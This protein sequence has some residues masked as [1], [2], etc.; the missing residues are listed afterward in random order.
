VL[1]LCA[2]TLLL[3]VGGS[4]ILP[5]LPSYLRSHGSTPGI[6]GIIMASYFAASV[7]TQYPAGKISDRFGRR[8]I[9]LGGLLLFAVGSVGFAFAAAAGYAVLFRSLQG[10]G[11]GAV[12]V[13][14]AA[15][16]ASVVAPGDRG[17]A[18]GAL[19]GSQMLALAIG[20][21][22]G[23]AIGTASMRV[24]FLAAAAS[25]LVALAP[26]SRIGRL[27]PAVENDGSDQPTDTRSQELE[28]L[29]GGSPAGGLS[30]RGGKRSFRFTAATNGVFVEFLATGLLIGVYEAC[31]TLLL[32]ARGASS[33]E[34]GLSWT[35]FALPFAVL[36]I[37]AGVLAEHFDR[38]LLAIG[39]LAASGLFC[40]LYPFLH[41]V[42]LLV[43]LGSIEAACSVI[44]APA[45]VLILT[46]A[47]PA[48]A[49]GEAQG[50]LGAGRTAAT[51]AA[52]GAAGA[53]F[54]LDPAIPFTLIAFLTIVACLAMAWMWRGIPGRGVVPLAADNGRTDSESSMAKGGG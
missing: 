21:L 11:A 48:A 17:G 46:D 38:R 4:A 29:A 7:V 10:I 14:A 24:L 41:N 16:I 20:P 53:L 34:I 1:A 51:A 6:V 2:T 40:G 9:L 39:G 54:G 28:A 30:L 52:A 18:F 44:G 42:P 49:Q 32:D 43:G 22:V 25:A 37:P 31:W 12:S 27:R 8:I 50:A 23:S 33:L 36:S 26:M 5:L 47:T 13:A 3:W 19:Y 35:L 15:T 45:A